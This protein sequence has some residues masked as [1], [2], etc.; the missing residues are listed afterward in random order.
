MELPA[1]RQFPLYSPVFKIE[2][3]EFRFN[4]DRLLLQLQLLDP[5]RQNQFLS[6]S[7]ECRVNVE[8]RK[9]FVVHPVCVKLSS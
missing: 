9:A 4:Y 1:V 2:R 8:G 5:L 7:A 3:F 6:V